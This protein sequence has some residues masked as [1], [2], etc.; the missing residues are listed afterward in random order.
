MIS[1][2]C[3]LCPHFDCHGH[4]WWRAVP[5]LCRRGEGRVSRSR[6]QSHS[7]QAKAEPAFLN[8][9]SPKRLIADWP[10]R[11]P[12]C[13]RQGTAPH[14]LPEAHG[15]PVKARTAQRAG[16]RLQ[17]AVRR[18]NSI[19][20]ILYLEPQFP[21]PYN[22]KWVTTVPTCRTVV[23]INTIWVLWIELA[24]PLQLLYASPTPECVC[25]WPWSLQ[26]GD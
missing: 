23:T 24:F 1:V 8:S 11:L 13:A 9:W 4:A 18:I 16:V 14:R 12:E 10:R 6:S 21:H 20:C 26:G 15:A 2:E 22:V 5:T 3:V 25:V 17:F 7:S 19:L